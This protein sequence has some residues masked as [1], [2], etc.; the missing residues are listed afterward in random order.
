[1]VFN[2]HTEEYVESIDEDL[3]AEIQVM[4]ADSMLGNKAIFDALVLHET[5]CVGL[6]IEYVTEQEVKDFLLKRF[7]Q[8]MAD[9]FK[10]QYLYPK[11]I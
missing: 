10:S 2:G 11:K 9:D 3:F 5:Y 7:N 8:K 4:Y 1:M 6:G